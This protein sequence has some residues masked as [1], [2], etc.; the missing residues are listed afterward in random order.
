MKFK[1]NLHD[2]YSFYCKGEYHCDQCPYSWEERNYFEDD[3]DAGCYIFG[4]LRDTCRLLP[5]FRSVIGWFKKRRYLYDYN[6]QY[7]DYPEWCEF[8]EKKENTL[9]SLIEKA[10]EEFEFYQPHADG[11]SVNEVYLIDSY[12][13]Y[14]FVRNFSPPNYTCR[15]IRTLWRNTIRSTTQTALQREKLFQQK[16]NA[17]VNAIATALTAALQNAPIIRKENGEEIPYSAAKFVGE[18]A[19]HIGLAYMD[20]MGI[21]QPS[22]KEEIAYAI[23]RTKAYWKNAIMPYF[24]KF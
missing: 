19:K 12:F 11:Y 23:K 22:K 6:S 1:K 5:P 4:E 3:G 13:W 10:L 7:N 18:N 2:A 24:T 17:Y 14:E 8:T 16:Q 20:A 9:L 15:S 21:T